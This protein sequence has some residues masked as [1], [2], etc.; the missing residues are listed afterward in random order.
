MRTDRK[1]QEIA[2]RATHLAT[3]LKRTFPEIDTNVIDFAARLRKSRF[4]SS[5][6][7][8]GRL[9]EDEYRKAVGCFRESACYAI[10]LLRES[11]GEERAAAVGRVIGDHLER[12]DG[13]GPEGKR[14]GEVLIEAYILNLSVAIQN[15]LEG[16]P[17][18]NADDETD[19]VLENVI[20]LAGRQYPLKVI[21]RSLRPL[22]TLLNDEKL[23]EMAA[24]G[25]ISSI[26]FHDM[27]NYLTVAMSEFE[28]IRFEAE[29]GNKEEIEMLCRQG[30]SALNQLLLFRNQMLALAKGDAVMMEG[31][32]NFT[33]DDALG[34]LGNNLSH[35]NVHKYYAE[36]PKIQYL[37]MGLKHVFV[38]LLKNAGRAIEN[39][40]GEIVIRTSATDR[41]IIV[42]ISDNGEGM[43][44]EQLGGILS[45]KTSKE[46]ARGIGVPFC[47]YI[48]GKHDG[49]IFYQS[50]KGE[51]TTVVIT[52]PINTPQES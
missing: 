8:G 18:R 26:V 6:E 34:L 2:Q 39:G 7:R 46:G 28:I 41:H 24:L 36:L 4:D 29:S 3:H 22:V 21:S 44:A 31:D 37:P 42:T 48:L 25:R 30:I 32:I 38:N 20:A 16:S 33:I 27:G 10:E 11:L 14:G 15:M 1:T 51:G 9:S 35:V 40:N 49:N 50:E 12:Y 45:G 19:S 47:K 17:N 23:L 43:D 5:L 13:R 52:L